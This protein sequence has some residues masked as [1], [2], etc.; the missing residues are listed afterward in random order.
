[1]NTIIQIGKYEFFN[2]I[3]NRWIII[4]T[5]LLVIFTDL[6]FRFGG[7]NPKVFVSLMNVVLI[8]IPLLSC[9][10]GVISY[11]N[12]R[13]F[14]ELLLSQ[15]LDRKLLY[16]GIYLGIAIPLSL[17]F[18]VGVGLP[19]FIH[20]DWNYE[21]FWSFLV[22]LTS[23]IFL[24]LIFVAISYMI[25]VKYEEKVKGFGMVLLLW[26]FF[27]LIFDGLFLLLLILFAEYPLEK[28]SI[29]FT[30]FNPIDLARV[31]LLLR[32]DIAALM[33]YT[34]AVFH[35]FFGSAMGITVSSGALLLWISIPFMLGLRKFT[36]KDF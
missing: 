36:K 5:I 16:L 3:R 12:S 10:F 9:M 13:E 34:G 19:F 18:I 4:Y 15:P 22:L 11:Y 6:L 35:K 7:D 14:I 17:G 32:L 21:K 29:I 25:A 1:M 20:A 26:F 2:I 33:G 24:T 28:F 31:L 30:L 23:G 8:L 27:T